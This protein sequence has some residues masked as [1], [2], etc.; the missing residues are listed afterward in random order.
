M[1]VVPYIS[2]MLHARVAPAI[3]RA[4]GFPSM[5]KLPAG[6][7]YAYAALVNRLWAEGDDLI[8]IEHDIEISPS[9]LIEFGRCPQ[10]WCAHRYPLSANPATPADAPTTFGFGCVRFR[11]ELMRA[12]PEAVLEAIALELHPIHPPGSWPI[13]DSQLSTWL[14]RPPRSV[15][16]HRHTPDVT[17]HHDYEHREPVPG[18]FRTR[19]WDPQ[20]ES[21]VTIEGR[22]LDWNPDEFA[23]LVTVARSAIG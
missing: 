16:P 21:F 1:I 2:G 15:T 3:V 10:V 22:E 19:A 6:D 7:P 23:S 13:F 18:S 12:W 4:G 9:V 17:H 8:I 5:V 11:G 14:S 20:Q